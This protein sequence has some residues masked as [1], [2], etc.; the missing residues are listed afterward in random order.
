MISSMTLMMP[1]KWVVLYVISTRVFV[2]MGASK[3][4]VVLC[5][6]MSSTIWLLEYV[7]T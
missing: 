6:N 1:C 4:E 5:K 2:S 3:S 7:S